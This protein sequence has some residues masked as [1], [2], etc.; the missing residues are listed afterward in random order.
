MSMDSA[1]EE[2]SSGCE[3]GWTVYFEQSRE[4]EDDSWCLNRTEEEEE[5]EEDLS[6]VSDASSGPAQVS[7]DNAGTTDNGG[8][9]GVFYSV[10]TDEDAALV[11]KPRRGKRARRGGKQL[12]V[13]DQPQQLLDDT[14]SSRPDFNYNYNHSSSM[15]MDFTQDHFSTSCFQAGASSTTHYD[16]V[17]SHHQYHWY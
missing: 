17:Q 2:Y 15:V 3:S 14:A 4:F 7:Q 5:E 6:M 10:S 16:Q 13:C 8:G 1:T 9:G 11:K 12:D